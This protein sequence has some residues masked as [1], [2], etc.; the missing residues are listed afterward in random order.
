MKILRR[1]KTAFIRITGVLSG[2]WV[3]VSTHTSVMGTQHS[4]NNAV[5]EVCDG[6]EFRIF[7]DVSHPLNMV[8]IR[9]D[10]IKEIIERNINSYTIVMQGNIRICI[11]RHF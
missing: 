9:I 8:R 7:S 11:E 6:L 4:F 3:D 2:H 5:F 10:T 1:Y